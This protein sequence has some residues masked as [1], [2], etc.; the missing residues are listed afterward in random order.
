MRAVNASTHNSTLTHTD[1]DSPTHTHADK[2]LYTSKIFWVNIWEGKIKV[3]RAIWR[4]LAALK[5]RK[6]RRKSEAKRE[7]DRE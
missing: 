3:E 7:K 1:K 4:Q 5:Q 2:P 6:Q